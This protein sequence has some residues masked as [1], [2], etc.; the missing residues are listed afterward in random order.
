MATPFRP[1]PYEKQY[2]SIGRLMAVWSNF[3]ENIEEAIDCLERNGLAE[4][5][6]TPDR[7]V[8]QRFDHF[9]LIAAASPHRE[10]LERLRN[11]RAP[12]EKIKKLRDAFAH[13]SVVCW[14]EGGDL[15]EIMAINK[16][17][18]GAIRYTSDPDTVHEHCSLLS[19]AAIDLHLAARRIAYSF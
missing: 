11:A 17:R 18:R 7:K 1:L 13:G 4:A 19:Q 2:A 15:P 12:I 8:M 5:K 3:V 9:M 10:A 16:E 6:A 14:S